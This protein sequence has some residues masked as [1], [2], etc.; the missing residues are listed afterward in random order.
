MALVDG[1]SGYPPG[2]R[3]RLWL[4]LKI[5][6]VTQAINRPLATLA[7]TVSETLAASGRTGHDRSIA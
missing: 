1:R 2:P 6:S 3:R 5:A 4:R 7:T